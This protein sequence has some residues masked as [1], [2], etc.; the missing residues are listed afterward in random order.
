MGDGVLGFCPTNLTTG[1]C[2]KELKKKSLKQKVIALAV[3]LEPPLLIVIFEQ[4]PLWGMEDDQ[5]GG[6]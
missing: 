2:L 6:G 1:L 5:A 4:Q 3:Y